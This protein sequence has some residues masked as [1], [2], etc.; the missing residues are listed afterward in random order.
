MSSTYATV[1]V[2]PLAPPCFCMALFDLQWSSSYA[3]WMGNWGKS[4]GNAGATEITHKN[5]G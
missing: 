1:R 3:F 5:A 2:P 4:F